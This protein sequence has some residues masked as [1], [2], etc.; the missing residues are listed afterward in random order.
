MTRLRLLLCC[1]LSP[2]ASFAQQSL[3]FPFV[4]CIDSASITGTS[5]LASAAAAGS[6]VISL[7]QPVPAGVILTINPGAPNEEVVRANQK[8]GNGPF[9]VSLLTSTTVSD[10]AALGYA[11]NAGEPVAFETRGNSV[12]FG[13]GNASANPLT[14]VPGDLSNLISPG[15]LDQGQPGTF[16]PGVQRSQLVLVTPARRNYFWAVDSQIAYAPDVPERSCQFTPP[17]VRAETLTLARGT[18]STNV[19]IGT[20]ASTSSGPF[21]AQIT[22][23]FHPTVS[24][25]PRLNASTDVSFAN[26]RVENGVVFGDV[27][28]AP[29]ALERHYLFALTVNAANS[30][31]KGFSTGIAD[32]VS[33]CSFSVAPQSLSTAY[34]NTPYTTS[35]QAPGAAAFALEG[36]GLPLGL[37]LTA[38][39]VLSGTPQQTG[40]FPFTLRISGRDGCFQKIPYTLTVLGQFCAAN[41]TSQVQITL[42]G[43]RQNLVT[44]RWQQTVTLRNNTPSAIF[45][46]VAL[47]LDNLSANATVLNPAGTTTCAEPAGRPFFLAPIGESNFFAAG[48]SVSLNLEFTTTAAGAITYTPRVIA[49]GALR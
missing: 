31:V 34:M 28:A 4:E 17:V 15:N 33:E 37:T 16:L 5:V 42:G 29:S 40:T 49:G 45:G 47:A 35:F 8:E 12:S 41:I 44:R 18:T 24:A 19:R 7:S 46:P 11:H 38:A 22:P 9:S 3:V 36:P 32:V 25:P 10:R 27:T 39:G 26:I 14:F 48:T 20:F 30:T 21:T 2:L 1:L 23:V 13:Y 6:S 43:F